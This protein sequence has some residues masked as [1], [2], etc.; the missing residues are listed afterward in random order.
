MDSKLIK[1]RDLQKKD[2]NKKKEFLKNK[3]FLVVNKSTVLNCNNLINQKILLM[4]I[5]L[6]IICH[7][8]KSDD[9]DLFDYKYKNFIKPNFYS[10]SNY[11]DNINQLI[12]INFNLT[13]INFSFIEKFRI[14]KVVYNIDFYDK[15][16]NLKEPSDLTLYNNIHILC[17]KKEI[18]SQLFFLS[19]ANIKQNKHFSCIFFFNIDEQIKF[20][21]KI[22]QNKKKYTFKKNKNKEFFI[23]TNINY[24]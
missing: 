20:G 24:I 4:I 6:I 5:F 17:I 16:N 13:S 8:K 22:Y 21:I 7:F 2:E 3:F 14:I 12:E 1:S 11:F 23:F 9:I 19:L 18:K 10:L 15:N